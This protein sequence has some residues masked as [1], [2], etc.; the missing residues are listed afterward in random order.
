MKLH[1]L[2][3][4]VVKPRR[5]VGRGHGSGRGKTAGRGTKGQ[6]SRESIRVGYEGGQLP[7]IKRL[8]LYRG[9]LKQRPVSAK[10]IPINISALSDFPKGTEVTEESLIKFNVI[11]RRMLGKGHIK[12]LGNGELKQ[13]L[14]I[15]LPVSKRAA[16]KIETAGGTI[17]KP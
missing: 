8:P 13:A 15:K 9:K 11:T 3:K 6:K 12:I 2:P 17:V 1:E 16:S 10:F 5:R 7:I 14:T 4:I